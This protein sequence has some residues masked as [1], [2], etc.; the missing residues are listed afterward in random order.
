MREI[1]FRVWDG[2]RLVY[3]KDFENINFRTNGDNFRVWLNGDDPNDAKRYILISSNK[4]LEQY[5]GLKD[6]N[7]K[8]IYEGDVIYTNDIFIGKKRQM[9]WHNETAS[10][11]TKGLEHIKDATGKDIF[12]N[13]RHIKYMSGKCEIIG[14][15]H[16]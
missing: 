2:E 4:P 14:N 1:K 5:T 13:F 15:I 12:G 9:V 6:K 8:E 7:G 16:E 11:M 10:F 3:S